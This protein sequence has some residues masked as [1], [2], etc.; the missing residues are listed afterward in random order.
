ML[1]AGMFLQRYVP[2]A[3]Q[4]YFNNRCEADAQKRRA[5]GSGRCRALLRA[6][7][8]ARTGPAGNPVQIN[9]RSSAILRRQADGNWL[10]ALD[11]PWGT[12]VV[13]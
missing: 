11:N 6:V 10:I 12:D 4:N 7:E 9:G 2:I 8:F 5:A 3:T 13:A 1:T